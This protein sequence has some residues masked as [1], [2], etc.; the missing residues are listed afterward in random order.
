MEVIMRPL[1]VFLVENHQDSA[2]YIR[3]Y[4]EH[5]GHEVRAAGDM[6]TA[7]KEL[8]ESNCDVLISDIGLPDGDGWQLMERMK[9]TK[10]AFSIAM[11]G[12]GSVEDLCR[13]RSA[14][15]DHH[16]VKPFLPSELIALLQQAGEA[17]GN[18]GNSN[19][20]DLSREDGEAGTRNMTGNLEV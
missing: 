5:F 15:Y 11:S 3:L 17:V 20:R 18:D 10:P 9:G 19:K 14:G 4:L 16:L 8:P 12:Y 13:S 2:K 1:R 7:L 6:A